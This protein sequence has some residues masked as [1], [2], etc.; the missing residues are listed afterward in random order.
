MAEKKFFD[1]VAELMRLGADPDAK[2]PKG[3]SLREICRRVPTNTPA[4]Y[5]SSELNPTQVKS[6]YNSQL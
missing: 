4:S 5:S 1:A 2:N 6:L 3:E